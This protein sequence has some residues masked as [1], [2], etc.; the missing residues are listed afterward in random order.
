MSLLQVNRFVCVCVCVH[1]FVC[2][3]DELV[4]AFGG[5]FR[6][7]K[8]NGLKVRGLCVCDELVHAFVCV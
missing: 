6:S 5:V 3:C 8:S 4:H 1:M 2:M 7:F